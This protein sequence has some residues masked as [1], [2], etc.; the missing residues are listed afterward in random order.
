MGCVNSSS[1]WFW[2][3]SVFPGELIV[4]VGGD[5]IGGLFIVGERTN[6]G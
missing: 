4:D 3:S 5:E 1:G 6:G 2:T